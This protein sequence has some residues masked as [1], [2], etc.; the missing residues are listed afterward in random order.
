MRE[1][2]IFFLL[3]SAGRD[4]D[5]GSCFLLCFLLAPHVLDIHL[6]KRLHVEHLFHGEDEASAFWRRGWRWS[7][8]GQLGVIAVLPRVELGGDPLAVVDAQL[9][10]LDG[11]GVEDGAPVIGD[12]EVV[13]GV[14]DDLEAFVHEDLDLFLLGDDVH[15][16][17]VGVVTQPAEDGGDA[18]HVG[19]LAD[20]GQ[21]L[22]GGGDARAEAGG[23]FAVVAHFARGFGFRLLL[24]GRRSRRVVSGHDM[25]CALGP[26]SASRKFDFWKEGDREFTRMDAN[27]E[28]GLMGRMGAME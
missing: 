13:G 23:D 15:F 25:R 9:G 12:D 28:M 14:I 18:G 6:V 19:S 2:S 24:F 8:G 21:G 16:P 11:D 26:R 22:R 3:F 4:G 1:V 10:T 17:E 7:G 5:V 27:E 20:S